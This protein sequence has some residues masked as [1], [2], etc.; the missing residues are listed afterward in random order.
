MDL[1]RR[2]DRILEALSEHGY[3]TVEE[4]SQRLG[5]SSVTIRT[6]LTALE[7]S[8]ALVRTHGGAM[9]TEK[10]SATRLLSTTM[11]E[12][13]V[14]K[15]AIAK[16]ASCFISDDSTIIVDSGSTTIHLMDYVK[17]RKLTVVT[18]SIPVV[19]QLKDD[20]S[21]EVFVI[22]GSLK[23]SYMGTIG[24]LANAAMALLNA[25]VYFMGA[26][27]FDRDGITST[28][29][30]EVELKKAMIKAADKVVFM[31]DSSKQGRKAFASLCSWED[32]DAFVT[33]SIDDGFRAFLEDKGIEVLI[34]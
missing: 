11:S 22:G 32:I 23:R 6:D 33:D 31:A 26:A 9:K 3:V 29:L 30:M 20:R 17:G 19:E 16:K 34:S 5:V 18:N 28:N 12:Y 14:Q 7:E 21:V 10:K 24:P 1:S 2:R 15:K 8:G 4:L 25:D 13:E 27:N